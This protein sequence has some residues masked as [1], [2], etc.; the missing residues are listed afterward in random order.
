[1][2]DFEVDDRTLVA[3]ALAEIIWR[4]EEDGV[5]RVGLNRAYD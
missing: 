1:M 3:L 5:C 4:K 2:T